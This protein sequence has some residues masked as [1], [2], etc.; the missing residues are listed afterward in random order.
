[1]TPKELGRAKMGTTKFVRPSRTTLWGGCGIALST[2]YPLSLALPLMS[3][4]AYFGSPLLG[5]FSSAVFAIS[6]GI[7]AFGTPP[8]Q[9]VVG[10]SVLGKAALFAY[11]MHQ[12]ILDLSNALSSN[13]SWTALTV[14]SNVALVIVAGGLAAS[15]VA[16]LTIVRAGVLHGVARW[17]L[18]PVS[19]A[20]IAATTL[21]LIPVQEVA[22]IADQTEV[23]STLLLLATGIAYALHGRIPAVKRRL[24]LINMK[25]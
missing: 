25:W 10:A 18:I 16:A 4:S 3:S 21:G 19:L 2:T 7:L 14:E 8:E 6:L 24:Q 12:F 1:V 11:G 17:A 20:A 15:L 9:G 5:L 23:V 13:L 22:F